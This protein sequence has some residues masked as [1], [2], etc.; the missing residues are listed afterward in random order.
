MLQG[1]LKAMKSSLDNKSPK[2]FSQMKFKSGKKQNEARK[3]EIK[4][5]NN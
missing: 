4:N 3:R 1:K 2:Q 5:E